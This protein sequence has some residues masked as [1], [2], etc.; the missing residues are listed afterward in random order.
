MDVD[1]IL[2]LMLASAGVV[3]CVGALVLAL[4]VAVAA[5]LRNEPLWLTGST[6]VLPLLI[7]GS[8]MLI[9]SVA[10]KEPGTKLE[11]HWLAITVTKPPPELAA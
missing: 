6:P 4:I 10:L 2:R 11:M 9:A 7:I 5:A 1:P 8:R 3:L